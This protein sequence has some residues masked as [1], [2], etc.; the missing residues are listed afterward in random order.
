VQNWEIVRSEDVPIAREERRFAET[1]GSMS[2]SSF[3]VSSA[4]VLTDLVHGDNTP[5]IAADPL[6]KF[7]VLILSRVW[8]TKDGVRFGNW[9][10]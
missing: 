4:E 3:H 10:F 6:L 8:V 9:I 1:D 2:C 7:I 5:G